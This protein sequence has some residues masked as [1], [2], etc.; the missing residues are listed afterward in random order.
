GDFPHGL[1]GNQRHRPSVARGEPNV[2]RLGLY[3]SKPP[4]PRLVVDLKSAR[5][6]QIFPSGRTVMIKVMGGASATDD[7]AVA[8]APAKRAALVAATY[9]TSREPVQV[10]NAPRTPLEVTFRNGSLSIVA[11]KATL[12]EVRYA[13]Q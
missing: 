4:V 6:Y 9:T 2:V 1:P 12:S 13:V 3:Q 7:S 10:V 5:S 11:N 8:N